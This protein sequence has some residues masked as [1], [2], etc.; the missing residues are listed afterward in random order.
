MAHWPIFCSAWFRVI[1]RGLIIRSCLEVRGSER[2]R[3]VDKLCFYS[4][5][6]AEFLIGCVLSVCGGAAEIV[7]ATSIAKPR[8]TSPN[9]TGSILGFLGGI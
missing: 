7:V 3:G 6:G 5:N 4:S 9:E 1:I 8:A 2:G